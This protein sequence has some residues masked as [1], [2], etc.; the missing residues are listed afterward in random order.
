M[1]FVLTYAILT[2]AEEEY[3][4]SDV[5]NCS[6]ESSYVPDL[7]T[8]DKN[9]EEGNKSAIADDTSKEV[10]HSNNASTDLEASLT[11]NKVGHR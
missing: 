3:M 4:H 8:S 2:I 10:I 9:T 1:L 6:N 5:G 7:N 11:V